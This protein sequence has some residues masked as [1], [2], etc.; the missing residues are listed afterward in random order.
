ML[1]AE[2]L[3]ELLHYDP[4]TGIFTW[5]VKPSGNVKAGDRAGS[6]NDR[7]YLGI[8]ISNHLYISHRLVWLYVYRRWPTNHIDHINGN[9][10]DNRLVNLREATNHQNQ[11][12]AA[13]R[14]DNKS[15]LKGVWWHSRD[16]CWCSKIRINGKSRHLGYFDTAEEAHAVYRSA[17]IEAFGEFANPSGRHGQ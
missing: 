16:K 17:A 15:G 11:A 8:G 10:I 2:R 13:I 6:P 9:K 4:T 5:L 3:R 1:T 12:N 7:G 14:K